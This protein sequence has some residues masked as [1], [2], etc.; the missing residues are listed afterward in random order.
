MLEKAYKEGKIKAIGISNFE[1][2]YINE[3]LDKFEIKPQVIQVEAHPYYTQDELRKTLDKYDIK[4]MSWYPIGHGD[5]KII[6]ENILKKLGKKYNKSSVQII[7]RWH[8]QM[9]FIVIPGSKNIEHIKDNLDILNFE[10]T[11]DE[12]NEISKINKNV[13]YYNRTD[14]QLEYFAKWQPEYEVR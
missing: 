12:M 9:G 11:K 6:E 4:L 13:R 1:G 8:L 7:L 5:K 10:L 2:K 14:E 3:I